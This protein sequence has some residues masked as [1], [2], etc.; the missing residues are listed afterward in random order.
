MPFGVRWRIALALL[1][2]AQPF[3]L[4]PDF[5][6][7]IGFADN[8]VV[9]TWAL[10]GAVRRAGPDSVARHWRGSRTELELLYRVGRLGAPPPVEDDIE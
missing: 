7:V 4:I 3:N 9:T 2:N 6:P 8:V 5:I 10:R 1:Y